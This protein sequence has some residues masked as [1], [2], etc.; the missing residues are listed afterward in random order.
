[1]KQL[2]HIPWNPSEEAI[3]IQP[4]ALVM[5]CQTLVPDGN[6]SFEI[7]M[8]Q[9]VLITHQE[10]VIPTMQW[11]ATEVLLENPVQYIAH[12]LN[13]RFALTLTSSDSTNHKL[14]PYVTELLR[15]MALSIFDSKHHKLNSRIKC[16]ELSA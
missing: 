4:F 16:Y 1:M 7:E 8:H 9:L 3:R 14:W 6:S 10:L 12:E 13:R 11:T 15:D 2:N 5:D